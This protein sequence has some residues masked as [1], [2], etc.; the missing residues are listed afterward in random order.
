MYTTTTNNNNNSNNNNTTT[1][2]NNNNNNIYIYID[3]YI[4]VHVLGAGFCQRFDTEN[5]SWIAHTYAGCVSRKEP[6]STNEV[7]SQQTL[8]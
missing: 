8:L 5:F 4:C 7:E 3:M 2:N 6:V 1:T